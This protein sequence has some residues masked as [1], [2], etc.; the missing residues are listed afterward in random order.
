MTIDSYHLGCPAWGIKGWVGNLY[1]SDARPRDYLAQYASVFNTV[2]GNTTFYSTPSAENVARWRDQVPASFRFCFKLPQ[3]I[4][5]HRGL[6]DASSETAEFLG[7][8]APMGERLG[9]FMIQL[10]P[11]FGPDRLDVLD[12]FLRALP[13]NYRFAV[14]LRHP[15]CFRTEA[16]ERVNELLTERGCE[17]IVMDTRGLH[18]GGAEHPELAAARHS[19]PNLPVQALAL[20]RHPLLRFIGHPAEAVNLPWMRRWARHVVRWIRQDRRPYLMVHSPGDIHAPRLAR[21]LHGL[22]A[23]HLDVGEM[24]P[25]PGEEERQKGQLSLL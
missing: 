19:K 20:S 5:H 1:R 24:P 17:R 13:G 4:T 12:A 16:F 22:I 8:M 6:I 21:R 14:E 23:E 7:R 9:P 25:W 2:E 3:T 15:A 11:S 10:P 18:S